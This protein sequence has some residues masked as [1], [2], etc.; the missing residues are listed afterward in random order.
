MSL[1]GPELP[2]CA[3]HKVVS[4]LGY[5]G[6][7]ADVVLTAALGPGLSSLVAAQVGRYLRY[8]G[9]RANVAATGAPDP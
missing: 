4:Y 6:R 2:T 1:I 8:T 7:D 5:S 9:R 3:L